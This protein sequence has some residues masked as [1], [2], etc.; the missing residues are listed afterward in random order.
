L[1]QVGQPR[2][3]R[4][5]PGVPCGSTIS[6]LSAPFSTSLFNSSHWAEHDLF[7]TDHHD[8]ESRST[9]PMNAKD[10][11]HPRVDFNEFINGEKL[12]QTD[13]VLGFNLALAHWHSTSDLPT[14]LSTVARNG[15]R[16]APANFFDIDQTRRSRNQVRIEYNDSRV[17]ALRLFGQV[18]FMEEQADLMAQLQN[19]T[20]TYN[21]QTG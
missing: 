9:H 12:A 1:N 10:A 18:P 6:R 4:L 11:D 13:V 2:G 7:V 15:V 17:M 3:Y 20:A 5:V 8:N 14:T 16:F 21:F 19:Y